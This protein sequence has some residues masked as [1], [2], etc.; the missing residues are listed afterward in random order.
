ML[1][2][3]VVGV[4]IPVKIIVAVFFVFFIVV[5]ILAGIES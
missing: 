5:V 1:V 4:A 2:V 3:S